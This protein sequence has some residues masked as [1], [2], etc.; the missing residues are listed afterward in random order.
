MLVDSHSLARDLRPW[1]VNAVQFSRDVTNPCSYP[2]T[3]AGR[4]IAAGK[5]A[6]P[7]DVDEAEGAMHEVELRVMRKVR[8]TLL[9]QSAHRGTLRGQYTC[10]YTGYHELAH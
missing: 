1:Q 10:N 4:S 5:S 2:S 7:L 9:K 8:T 6:A 3:L